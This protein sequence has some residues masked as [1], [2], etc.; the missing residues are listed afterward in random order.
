VRPV[1]SCLGEHGIDPAWESREALLLP[2]A[3]DQTAGNL[4]VETALGSRQNRGLEV[5]CFVGSSKEGLGY[6][7]ALVSHLETYGITCEVWTDAFDLGKT[8]V[9]GLGDALARHSFAVLIATG[10]P[11]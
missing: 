11:Y 5:T 3:G 7:N 1:G 8:T 2:L 6:A 4:L 9:E 10:L